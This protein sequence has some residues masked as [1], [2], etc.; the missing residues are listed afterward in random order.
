MKQTE[1]QLLQNITRLFADLEDATYGKERANGRFVPPD[2][3][4]FYYCSKCIY[5]AT[6]ELVESY[7]P[8]YISKSDYNFI[9][10]S[11][12]TL[13]LDLAVFEISRI[14]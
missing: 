6:D 4:N 10:D 9:Y 5:D 3:R 12:R 13:L 14:I 7:Q 11:K 1:E 8:N 2:A